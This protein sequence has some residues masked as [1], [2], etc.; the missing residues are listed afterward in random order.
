MLKVVR[1]IANLGLSLLL[2]AVLLWGGCLSCSQYF[3]A[4]ASHG[5]CDPVGHCGRVPAH[6]PIDKDC[7]IQ[8]MA[9][10]GAN[11]TAPI[12]AA[13]VPAATPPPP[14][15]LIVALGRLAPILASP[16]DLCKLHSVFRT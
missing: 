12:A 4:P 11:G 1:T 7:S 16:P 10:P 8:A 3:M 13:T 14:A 2:V 15:Q 5:C 6:K 9:L